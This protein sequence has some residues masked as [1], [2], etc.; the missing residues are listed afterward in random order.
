MKTND[1][2]EEFPSAFQ[3]C[4]SQINFISSLIVVTVGNDVQ[5]LD[6]RSCSQLLMVETVKV[7]LIIH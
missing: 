1:V 5:E 7:M 2:T 6:A 4:K 3:F